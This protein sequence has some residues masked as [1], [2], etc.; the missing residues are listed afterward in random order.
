MYME[1]MPKKK[2]S[3]SG[4]A[5]GPCGMVS[6]PPIGDLHA[7]RGR[8]RCD[9]CG[10][11]YLPDSSSDQNADLCPVCRRTSVRICPYCERPFRTDAWLHDICP[12]CYDEQE[13]RQCG[14]RG[15]EGEEDFDSLDGY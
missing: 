6:D 5:A 11:W 4:D 3:S 1:N 13:W 7:P 9:L 15:D 8:R 2:H 12:E 14:G 10:E